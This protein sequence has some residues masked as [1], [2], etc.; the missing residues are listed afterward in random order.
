MCVC[1]CMRYSSRVIALGRYRIVENVTEAY[2]GDSL[3][4]TMMKPHYPFAVA[5]VCC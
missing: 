1:V 4:Q 5:V 2:L 3:P